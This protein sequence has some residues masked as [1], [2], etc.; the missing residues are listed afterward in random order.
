MSEGEGERGQ[1]R[2]SVGCV[3]V[4]LSVRVSVGMSVSEGED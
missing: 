2:M 3:S 1:V 4:W